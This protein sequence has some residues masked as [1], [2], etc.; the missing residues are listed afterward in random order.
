M[1]YLI[2]KGIFDLKA[3]VNRC[4]Q[5][6]VTRAFFIAI[7]HWYYMVIIFKKTQI[8]KTNKHKYDCQTEGVK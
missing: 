5:C 4:K 2:I 7:V 1:F 8:N 3:T 6:Y